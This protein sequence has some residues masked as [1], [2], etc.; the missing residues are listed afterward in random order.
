MS[1]AI[2]ECGGETVGEECGFCGK[3]LC[4][5][6]FECGGGFC[7]GPHTQEQI[8]SYED[9]MTGKPVSQARKELR[10][11]GVLLSLI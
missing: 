8:D 3:P 10:Q 11:L 9:M 5:M 2:C 6:C 4:P 1:N 7:S